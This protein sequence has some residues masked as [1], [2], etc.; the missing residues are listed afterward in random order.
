MYS[1]QSSINFSAYVT[2][3][4]RGVIRELVVLVD[5]HK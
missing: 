3:M 4:V 5:G 1:S 2:G